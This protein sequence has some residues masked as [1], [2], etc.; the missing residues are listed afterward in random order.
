M[1][2]GNA[3]PIGGAREAAAEAPPLAVL[4]AG[5]DAQLQPVLL[6]IQDRRL[7]LPGQISKLSASSSA[8]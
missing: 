4:V 5:D 7:P 6:G 2:I 3:E 1:P 8:S